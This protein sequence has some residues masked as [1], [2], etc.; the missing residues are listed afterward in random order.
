M[1]GCDMYEYHGKTK[2]GDASMQDVAGADIAY[3]GPCGC[4][5]VQAHVLAVGQSHEGHTIVGVG[6]CVGGM[7][8][9]PAVKPR[10]SH[11][12]SEHAVPQG[13]FCIWRW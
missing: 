3:L 8:A 1:V 9:W 7:L 4:I 12:G 5:C 10:A 13:K 11:L 6:P 2:I